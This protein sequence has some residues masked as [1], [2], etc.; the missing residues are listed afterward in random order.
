MGQY[1]C[2]AKDG[3]WVYGWYIKTVNPTTEDTHWIIKDGLYATD[4]IIGINNTKF[5]KML[6][7]CYPVLPETVGQYTSLKDKNGKGREVWEGDRYKTSDKHGFCSKK[8]ITVIFD[9]GCFEAVFDKFDEF[10]RVQT[11]DS[12]LDDYSDSEYISNIHEHPDL[13]EQGK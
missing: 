13:L 11:L 8:C 12:F 10:H 5:P 7:G 6:Q 9:Y 2:L 1:R 4:I 3:K